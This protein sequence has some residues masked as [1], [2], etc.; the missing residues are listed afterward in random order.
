MARRELYM[1]NLNK[2]I[3]KLID[4]IVKSI[5]R[6]KSKEEPSALTLW[7]IPTPQGMLYW[8]NEWAKKL[9]R[10]LYLIDQQKISDEEIKEALR[11]PSRI[12]HFLWRCGDAVKNSSLDKKEKL[13]IIKQLFKILKIF[14]KRSL[15][16]ENGKNI[17]WSKSELEN[18]KRNLY[19]FSAKN[20]KLK[21]LISDIEAIL[22]LYTE[23]LYWAQHPLGHCFHGFYSEK[24][25]DLLV[26]EY[27]D[28]KPKVWSFSQDLNFS[29]IEIFELYKKKTSSKVKLEFFERSIQTT[30][31]LKQNL[32]KFALKIDGKTIKKPEEI[33]RCFEN[34]MSVIEKG[35]KIIQSLNQQ[36][37]IEKHADYWFYALKPLC[38]L[39]G[40]D[41][42]PP[43]QVRE[44]I[45][46]KYK[47]LDKIWQKMVKKRSK[48]VDL[49]YKQQAEILKKEF[50]PLAN[51]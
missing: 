34:L 1:Q 12:P 14:R 32:N 41:W 10:V 29:E 39:V 23:L 21:K 35:S 40:E 26:R 25:G 38:D 18:Y 6:A 33:S 22:Y 43:K 45:Y 47:K 36:Q 15:F 27:F 17:I 11:F 37:M 46:Q 44:N 24:R 20:K 51:F 19:W 4:I 48:M 3:D 7:P 49:S 9:Y 28:L 50:N 8:G 13:F 42:H 5:L 30:H 2:K 31:S 16:C